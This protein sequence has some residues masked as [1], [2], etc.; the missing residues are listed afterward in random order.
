MSFQDDIREAASDQPLVLQY[1]R[2]ITKA[3]TRSGAKVSDVVGALIA[4]L[5]VVVKTSAPPE[6]WPDAGRMI[7]EEIRRQLSN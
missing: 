5:C 4:N 2:A 7:A 1:A 3:G 6:H